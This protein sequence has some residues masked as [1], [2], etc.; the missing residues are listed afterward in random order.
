MRIGVRTIESVVRRS[1]IK[2]PS[3]T[4]ML[5]PK[6]TNMMFFLENLLRSVGEMRHPNFKKMFKTIDIMKT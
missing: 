4:K 6:Q 5:R 3:V 1:L 2:N